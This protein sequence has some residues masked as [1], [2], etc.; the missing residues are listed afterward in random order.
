MSSLS[1][2]KSD[3]AVAITRCRYYRS[4]KPTLECRRMQRSPSFTALPIL[5]A[6]AALC[7]AQSPAPADWPFYGGNPGGSRF[8]PVARITRDNVSKLVV[9][10]R[11]HTGE[12]PIDLP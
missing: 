4:T 7:A 8:S 1:S 2:T 12:P 6:L 5:V 9:A 11:Y 3:L 10:W